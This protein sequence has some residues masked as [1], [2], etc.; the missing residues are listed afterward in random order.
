MTAAGRVD[1]VAH[2]GEIRRGLLEVGACCGAPCRQPLP[3]LG[4]EGEVSEVAGGGDP[5]GGPGHRRHVGD[6]GEA[7]NLAAPG[8]R[9]A[10]VGAGVVDDGRQLEG[11]GVERCGQRLIPVDGVDERSFGGPGRCRGVAPRAGS[12]LP[13][14]F[15]APD[16]LLGLTARANGGPKDERR[17]H[18]EGE[19]ASNRGRH[20][21]RG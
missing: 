10:L 11:D 4:D 16:L 8:G 3:D 18:E 2:D 21:R 5:G 13:C 1:A 15:G 6:R 20:D 12:L 19:G 14:R 17:D 9:D 7:A